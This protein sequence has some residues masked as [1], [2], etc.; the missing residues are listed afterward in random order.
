[1]HE[2]MQARIS[3]VIGPAI[4]AERTETTGERREQHREG[5]MQF[6]QCLALHMQQRGGREPLS[7]NDTI[8][9]ARL[10]TSKLCR[11][12]AGACAGS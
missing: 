5:N 2:R 10:G 8:S 6:L 4:R 1:M 11:P 7:D 9:Y 12:P 3:I